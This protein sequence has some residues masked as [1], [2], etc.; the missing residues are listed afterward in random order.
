[1]PDKHLLHELWGNRNLGACQ[2]EGYRGPVC[3]HLKGCLACGRETGLLI[4]SPEGE[5]LTNSPKTVSEDEQLYGSAFG[6]T[7]KCQAQDAYQQ[8]A[9]I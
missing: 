3:K 8:N 6:P 7:T 5:I 9:F 1:M 4:K 2:A